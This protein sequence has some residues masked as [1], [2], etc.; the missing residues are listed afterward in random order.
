VEAARPN[1]LS[2][3]SLELEESLQKEHE[4]EEALAQELSM[5]HRL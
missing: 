5:V 3:S 4:R 1:Q 2:A